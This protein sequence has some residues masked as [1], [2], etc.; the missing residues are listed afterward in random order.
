M[1]A[2][3]IHS[4]QQMGAIV[5][6]LAN[7]AESIPEHRI[8]AGKIW[9]PEAHDVAHRSGREFGTSTRTSAGMMAALSGGLEWEQNKSAF[10]DLLKLTP[11]HENIIKHSSIQSRRTSEAEDLLNKE[12]PALTVTTDRNIGKALDIYRGKDPEEVLDRRSN[13]KT[14][15]FFRNIHDPEGPEVTVDF[16][17][18]DLVSNEM[19]PSREYSR[20]INS[21]DLVRG[22]GHSFKPHLSRYERIAEVYDI[23]ANRGVRG[24]KRGN[25]AQAALW[26]AGKDI[27]LSRPLKGGGQRSV[28]IPRKGESYMTRSGQPIDM[29][30]LHLNW[31]Q[32]G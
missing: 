12:Y 13:P 23:L 31:D 22:S 19:R 18:Y 3:D 27:E 29:G 6:R 14:N 7:F 20:G 5:R 4:P 32:L 25:Q 10:H 28:G 30:R 16:R 26:V 21:A 17:A 2:F 15:S 9:Y 1:P 24:F 8:A 11:E